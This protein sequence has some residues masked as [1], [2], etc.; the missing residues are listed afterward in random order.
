MKNTIYLSLIVCLVTWSNHLNAQK[1]TTPFNAEKAS[2]MAEIQT[3][4]MAEI[5]DLD[6]SQKTKVLKI[7]YKAAEEILKSKSEGIVESEYREKLN[8]IRKK[9]QDEIAALLNAKQKTKFLE[10]NQAYEAKKAAAQ[11]E[12]ADQ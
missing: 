6:A 2:E 4:K 1:L 9:Q 7:N 8:A 10:V 12:A 11:K 5:L 3:A